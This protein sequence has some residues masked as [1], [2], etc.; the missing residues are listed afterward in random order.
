VIAMDH[1][2]EQHHGTW[3]DVVLIERRSPPVG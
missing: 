3:R 1:D 2:D